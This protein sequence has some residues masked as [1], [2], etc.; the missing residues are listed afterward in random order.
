MTNFEILWE[1][2]RI[3]SSSNT[4]I[5]GL[6]EMLLITRFEILSSSFFL[7]KHS[8]KTVTLLRSKEYFQLFV[9]FFSTVDFRFFFL[10]DIT[11]LIR[12]N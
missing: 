12:G 4:V 11:Y 6:F 7:F 10:I 5:S 3:E 8:N 1:Q 2:N 9:F